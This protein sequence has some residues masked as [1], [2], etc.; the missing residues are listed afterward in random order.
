MRY[1]FFLF[2][3]ILATGTGFAQ[4]RRFY[5]GAQFFPNFSMVQYTH[6]SSVPDAV[7]ANFMESEKPLPNSSEHLYVGFQINPK[8]S[9]EIGIGYHKFGYLRP[10]HLV[11]FPD[12]VTSYEQR[13]TYNFRYLEVPLNFRYYFSNRFYA[14]TG[15][16]GLINLSSDQIQ[17]IYYEDGSTE[18]NSTTYP[19]EDFRKMNATGNIGVGFDVVSSP[20]FRMFVQPY[21]QYMF[22]TVHE[23]AP[24]NRRFHSI[25][26]VL[27]VRI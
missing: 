22:R 27:G 25:G 11:T 7:V 2:V 14:T 9:L 20:S 12:M 17:K 10:R 21:F 5:V 6:D 13:L 23:P 19:K 8:A 1:V 4:D 18:V 24:L 26:L 16:S 15:M 3:F